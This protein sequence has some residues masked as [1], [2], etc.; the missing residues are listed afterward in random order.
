MIKSFWSKSRTRE[1]L[2]VKQAVSDI[3]RR[4]A[5]EEMEVVLCAVKCKK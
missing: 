2:G 3:S 1:G 5:D 4:R